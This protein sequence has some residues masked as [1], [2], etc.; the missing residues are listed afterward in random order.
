LPRVERR[1]ERLGSVEFDRDAWAALGIPVGL[2]WLTHSSAD[3][4]WQVRMPGALGPVVSLLDG[5]EV[6][7]AVAQL[8]ALRDD[9]EALL[10]RR[11][12]GNEEYYRVSIDICAELAGLLRSRWQ[13]FG[14]GDAHAEVDRFF[15]ALAHECA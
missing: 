1:I 6:A 14:G 2:A 7:A 8:P 11:R 4:H 9:V 12:P 10:V 3:G 15:E 5:A 13:G